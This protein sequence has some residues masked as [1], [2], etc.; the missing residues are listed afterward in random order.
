MCSF[1]WQGAD[2]LL[3]TWNH[4]SVHGGPVPL[5]GVVFE[6]QGLRRGKAFLSSRWVIASRSCQWAELRIQC[7]LKQNGNDYTLPVQNRDCVTLVLLTSAFFWCTRELLIISSTDMNHIALKEVGHLRSVS[8][9]DFVT[10]WDIT[11]LTDPNLDSCSVARWLCDYA[12]R[13]SITDPNI[14]R[15][16]T[17]LSYFIPQ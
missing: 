2:S 7:F 8:F 12:Y 3:H 5:E 17:V 16:L 10:V 1:V 4:R 6:E 11:K 13:T 15:L 9:S 14:T